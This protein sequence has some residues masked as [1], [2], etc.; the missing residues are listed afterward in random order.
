M[1][2]GTCL[3]AQG[4]ACLRHPRAASAFLFFRQRCPLRLQQPQLG[5]G[6]AQFQSLS[7]PHRH[8]HFKDEDGATTRHTLR[9]CR[10]QLSTSHCR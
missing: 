9:H 3:V 2:V 10:H 6:R 4:P 7:A 1:R 8:L 5:A